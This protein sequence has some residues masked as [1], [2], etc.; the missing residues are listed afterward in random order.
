M[1]TYDPR[2]GIW[3]SDGYPQNRIGLYAVIVGVSRYD[4]LTGGE[5]NNN[6]PFELGQL[7]SSARTAFDVFEWLRTA[8]RH[9][10]AHL[11]KAWLR[12]APS[13]SELPLVGVTTPEATLSGISTALNE[14]QH[15]LFQ[16]GHDSGTSC[17]AL[18]FFSGHGIERDTDQQLL[19]PSDYWSGSNYNA[20]ISTRN[21]YEALATAPI[22]WQLIV[23]DACRNSSDLL[24]SFQNVIGTDVLMLRPGQ[25][26]QRTAPIL[27]ASASGM[28]AWSPKTSEERTV[29]GDALLSAL[30]LTGTP[31]LRPECDGT[32]CTI[33]LANLYRYVNDAVETI[34]RRRSVSESDP[35]V[36]G[37]VQK[38]TT[39]ITEV[40]EPSS[41]A[42]AMSEYTSL[43]P[44]GLQNTPAVDKYL[45]SASVEIEQEAT[46]I[47]PKT[48]AQLP[49]QIQSLLSSMRLYSSLLGKWEPLPIGLIIRKVAYDLETQNA[50]VS[51]WLA[52]PAHS[53][54]LLCH[55]ATSEFALL[56]PG[57]PREEEAHAILY[58]IEVNW[59]KDDVT[60]IRTAL[61]L[62]NKGK[63]GHAARLWNT[64]RRRGPF[65][66]YQSLAG[67]YGS[68]IVIHEL[69]RMLFDAKYSS[70]LAA[71]IGAMILLRNG[72]FDKSLDGWLTNLIKLD[73]GSDAALFYIARAEEA[74]ENYLAKFSELMDIIITRGMPFSSEAT[75][76]LARYISRVFGSSAVAFFGPALYELRQRF[77]AIYPGYR[78]GTLFTMFASSVSTGTFAIDSQ[79]GLTRISNT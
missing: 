21:I 46:H 14:W 59:S 45:K 19:L 56:L 24:D 29:F 18:F 35:V 31:P 48:F 10:G 64:Y 55:T 72:R 2:T 17:R 38:G 32:R 26:C 44:L 28:A 7:T 15:E 42:V 52:S 41:H 8:Y 62:D 3:T 16:L 12:L 1:S 5:S 34:L 13:V 77:D 33:D 67:P 11:V 23:A 54:W 78:T 6:P 58:D 40:D 30:A 43:N 65:A 50:I 27:Y 61:S 76:L 20:A 60:Q 22:P 4:Y 63:L 39:E 25:R 51:V 49:K 70:P 74:G 36:M 9:R 69:A 57:R 68:E 47:D 79:V 66:A 53:Y 73:Y 75:S 71:T 37:G